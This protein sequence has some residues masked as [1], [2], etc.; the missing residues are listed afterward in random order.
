MTSGSLMI[1]PTRILG[2]SEEYGSWSIS[3][4]FWGSLRRSP[5]L[6]AEMSRPANRTLP[7][8]GR[9]SATIILPIVVFPQPD[10]PTRPN[11]S[12]AFT[13]NDTSETACTAPALR[14]KIAPALTGYSLTTL[15]TSSSTEPGSTWSGPVAASGAG[16]RLDT[17]TA[18]LVPLPSVAPIGPSTGCQHANRCSPVSPVS[19]GSSDRH[20]SV[21]R[22][23]LAADRHP[24]GGLARSGGRPGML[25]SRWEASWLS[26]GIE[27]SSAWV[28]GR[29]ILLNRLPG[30]A[31]STMRPAYITLT[32][33]A[34]PA[35]TPMSSWI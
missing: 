14:C 22:L 6:R 24:A 19:G 16:R 29:S 10:S 2:S 30:S 4:R 8:F 25:S 13:V 18:V 1:A 3:C 9:S 20:L 26:R 5:P 11:V 12:P 33:S 23:H 15:R 17:V 32:P 31:L 28:Y 35:I 21:A 34:L 7:E 27:T